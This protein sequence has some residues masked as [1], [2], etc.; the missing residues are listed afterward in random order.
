MLKTVL[1]IIFYIYLLFQF[2]GLIFIIW[3]K[4]KEALNFLLDLTRKEYSNI[5]KIIP[6]KR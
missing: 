4:S 2:K 3:I 6:L 1:H 5:Y